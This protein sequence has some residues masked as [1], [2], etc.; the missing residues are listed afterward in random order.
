[1]NKALVV[2]GLLLALL[3]PSALAG[4]AR[5]QAGVLCVE[6]HG[7]ADTRFDVKRR[8]GSTCARGEERVALPRGLRGLRGP[9]G[10]AGARGPA[11]PAGATGGAGPQGLAGPAGAAGATGAVGPQGPKGETG[12]QGPPGLPPVTYTRV[13][14]FGGAFAPTN[15]T[16]TMTADCAKFGPYVDGGAAGGSVLFSGL[17]GM[18]LG[19]IVNLVYT[20]SFSSDI[21][22]AG[23]GAP[24]LR[25]FLEGGTHDVIFSPDTQPFP[26]VAEDVLHQW[27]VT[28]GTV[29]YDDDPGDGPDSP[30]QV[31]VAE[32]ADEVISG[33]FVTVGFSAGTNLTGCLRTL[34]VNES[35]FLFGS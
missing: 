9:R 8:P 27:D 35:V 23:E 33:I 21:D 2:G 6:L 22:T 29:R 14:A 12:P 1:M 13:T 19:D 30:W 5:T 3:V 17:N 16:V 25:V 18:K 28:E 10:P 11:G 24:Y 20:G 31:I 15:P 34:G 26:L 7:N 32:H 4:S